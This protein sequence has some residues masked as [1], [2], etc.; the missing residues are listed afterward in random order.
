MGVESSAGLFYDRLVKLPYNGDSKSPGAFAQ[1]IQGSAFPA[2][3]DQHW[4]EAIAL[5]NKL[6]GISPPTDG[7][8]DLT[9]EDSANLKWIR[10]YLEEPLTSASVVTDK[11]GPV[12]NLKD[13][14]R[15]SNG[16]T[17]LAAVELLASHGDPD[18]LT[19]LRNVADG[20]GP[21]ALRAQAILAD[22]QSPVQSAVVNNSAPQ[23]VYVDRQQVAAPPTAPVAPSGSIGQLTGAAID[24]LGALQQH[25]SEL[26]PGAIAPL[27]DLVNILKG[28]QA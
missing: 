27:G 6:A 8:G 18:S 1:Q 19:R 28:A 2:R 26:P 15:W 13:M 12:G 22:L 14:I 20:G 21:N 17:D 24:A 3:Y 16:N 23:V 11:Q 7:D 9:A 4:G 25:V 5:Y 10:A